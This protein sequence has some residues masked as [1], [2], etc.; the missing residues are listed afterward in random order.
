M[1]DLHGTFDE[2][3]SRKLKVWLTCS[4]DMFCL[5]TLVVHD[6][7]YMIV[8]SERGKKVK[9]YERLHKDHRFFLTD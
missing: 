7:L 6:V 2:A 4:V 3:S 8:L 9:F 5:T 1:Y